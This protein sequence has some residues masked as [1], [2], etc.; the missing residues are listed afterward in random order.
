M[1]LMAMAMVLLAKSLPGAPQDTAASESDGEFQDR[2]CSD[3]DTWQDAQDLF[4]AAGGPDSD[5][6][7]LDSDGDGNACESLP[8]FAG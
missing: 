8:G 4:L 3:F 6:H 1:D 2:N 5:P 7:H